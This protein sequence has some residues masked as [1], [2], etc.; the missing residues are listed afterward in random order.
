MTRSET[1]RDSAYRDDYDQDD[2][3]TFVT[4]RVFVGMAFDVA[5]DISDTYQAIKQVCAEKG[6]AAHR[7]DDQDDSGP[8]PVQILRAI[9]DAEFLIFDLSVERPN[10]YYELG[11]AHG[12]GNR[13]E[14][15][16]LVAKTGS[17]IHFDVAQLR[18]MFYDSAIDLQ[19]K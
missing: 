2:E 1:W 6:L 17:K 3:A 12:A 7:V 19:R 18:I 8:I 5:S 9:E 16:V 11:Y 14:E 4:G 10:V 13:S 15:I